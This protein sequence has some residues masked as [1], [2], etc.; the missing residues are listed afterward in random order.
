MAWITKNT[1]HEP[2]ERRDEPF[3]TDAMKTKL[4]ADVLPRFPTK[5][6]A[7]LPTLHEI[8]HTYGWIPPQ[9]LDEAATFLDIAPAEVLDTATFYEE[10]Y[11]K[12]KGRH[13]IQICQSIACELCG[14]ENLLDKCIE[15]L[16]I[17][18]GETTEDGRY[19]LVA[20]E[21]LG[22]CGGAPAVLLNETLYECVTWEHLEAEIDALK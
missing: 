13:L 4:E 19:T 11:L 10:Y 6:A 7:L 2:I 3:L 15:K 9:A 12:P 22:A 18:H 8:Q 14:H 1:A 17:E 16:G 5:R 21:C 20:L